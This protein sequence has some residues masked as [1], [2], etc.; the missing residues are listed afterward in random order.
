M[1][2]IKFKSFHFSIF[3]FIRV[4]SASS[5]DEFLLPVDEFVRDGLRTEA[6]AGGRQA[7]QPPSRELRRPGGLAP[8]TMMAS[9]GKSG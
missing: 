5:V 9:P 3:L 2:R 1:K 4:F 7:S 8:G 6:D